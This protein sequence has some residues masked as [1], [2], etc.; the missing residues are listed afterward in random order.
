VFVALGS[1]VVAALIGVVLGIQPILAV[2]FIVIAAIAVLAAIKPDRMLLVALLLAFLVDGLS[3]AGLIPSSAALLSDFTLVALVFVGSA[4]TAVR[5]RV[6]LPMLALPLLLL[7]A[8]IVASALVNGVA[9]VVALLGAR[10][11]LKYALLYLVIVMVRPGLPALRQLVWL[12]VALA[13]LQAP[14]AIV[15]SLTS[16]GLGPDFVTGT[17]GT[18]MS[19]VLTVWLLF[20]IGFIYRVEIGEPARVGMFAL[21]APMLLLVPVMLNGTTVAFLFGPLVVAWVVLS[22]GVRKNAVRIAL[23]LAL[24]LGAMG[25]VYAYYQDAGGLRLSDTQRV[26]QYISQRY[27]SD[28]GGRMTRMPLAQYA[29]S[30]VSRSA[31]TKIFGFGPGAA[32]RRSLAGVSGSLAALNPSTGLDDTFFSRMTL[33]LGLAGWFAMLVLAAGVV[34]MRFRGSRVPLSS[35]AQAV[36]DA[37]VFL[38]IVQMPLSLYTSVWT[39]GALAASFWLL[40]GVS[41]SLMRCEP[42]TRLGL[43]GTLGGA[44][45]VSSIPD[46]L[47]RIP[48]NGAVREQSNAVD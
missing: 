32:S 5:G 24:F 26:S 25:L 41:E 47:H 31:V 35:E 42:G 2:G 29:T 33:E 36:M 17:L 12:L 44:P 48:S 11:F 7:V 16:G 34:V 22:S 6:Q 39:T 8:V 43:V 40:A 13:F 38:A 15:Q 30:L 27:V 4:I 18:G 14:I 45:A 28:A 23:V 19:G 20:M 37:T 1:A 21:F 10:T 46:S 9:P 3:S